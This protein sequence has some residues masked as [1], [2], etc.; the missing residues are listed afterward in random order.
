MKDAEG[1]Y[2]VLLTELKAAAVD[3]AARAAR[4]AGAEVVFADNIPVAVEGDLEAAFDSIVE[5]AISRANT[6]MRP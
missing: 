3:V 6:R 4:S 1:S 5:R 2:E